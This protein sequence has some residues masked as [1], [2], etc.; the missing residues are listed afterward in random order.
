MIDEKIDLQN[1]FIKSYNL[2]CIGNPGPPKL[3]GTRKVTQLTGDI[4]RETGHLTANQTGK[5][6]G[7]YGTDLG[8]SFLYDGKLYFLFFLD[9]LTTKVKHVYQANIP[10]YFASP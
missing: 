9:Q 2:S 6:F 7:I 5:N 3:S 8:V 10:C 4:D 1:V